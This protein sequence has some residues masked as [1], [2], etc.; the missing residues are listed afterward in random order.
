VKRGEVYKVGL[1]PTI[2]SEQQKE[3]PCVIVKIT[4]PDEL[5]AKNPITLIVPITDANGRPG[6]LLHV[7]VAKGV[8]GMTKESRILCQQVRAIDKRRIVGPKIG[9]MPPTIMKLVDNGLR[10]ILDLDATPRDG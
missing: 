9:E 4:V 2:G 3:R 10:A 1:D 7:L 6:N 5:E 8:G